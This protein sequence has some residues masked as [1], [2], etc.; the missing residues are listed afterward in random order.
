LHAG[1]KIKEK[2]LKEIGNSS[3]I[4]SY[5]AFSADPPT[6]CFCEEITFWGGGYRVFPGVYPSIVFNLKH[7]LKCLFLSSH[8]F[9]SEELHHEFLSSAL[10]ILN[11]SEEIARRAKI[12]RYSDFFYKTSLYVP[13][14]KELEEL[15]RVVLFSEK[16]LEEVAVKCSITLKNIN[17]LFSMIGE[18]NAH[19]YDF[20]N[21]QLLVQ[22]ILQLEKNYIVTDP[23][24]LL[25]SFWQRVHKKI[26]EKGLFD[27]FSK[28]YYSAI[29]DSVI[30]YFGF[31]KIQKVPWLGENFQNNISL[32]DGVFFFDNDKALIT[33]LI[34]NLFWKPEYI[35]HNI[36]SLD[37]R[38]KLLLEKICKLTSAPNEIMY[39]FLFPYNDCG[40]TGIEVLNQ[41]KELPSDCRTLALSLDSLEIISI[42]EGG[43]SLFLYKY[44]QSQ[45]KNRLKTEIISIHPLSDYGYFRKQGYSYYFSDDNVNM[46]NLTDDIARSTR[47]EALKKIDAHSVYNPHRNSYTEVVRLHDERLPLYMPSNITST[48]G[49]LLEN[50]KLPIWFYNDENLTRYIRYIAIEF[51]DMLGYWIYEMRDYINVLF[52][53]L[54]YQ[55]KHLLIYVKFSKKDSWNEPFIGNDLPRE[56]KHLVITFKHPDIIE[57]EFFP[58]INSLIYGETNKGERFILSQFIKNMRNLYTHFKLS[59]NNL[60]DQ[61]IEEIIDK[62]MPISKKKKLSVYNSLIVP[63]IDPR[64][65]PI[66]RVVDEIDIDFLLDEIGEVIRNK[67][68]KIGD[69]NKEQSE[70]INK[71]IVG[72][73][74]EKLQN[75]IRKINGDNLLY[76]LI[77]QNEALTRDRKLHEIHLPMRLKISDPG[78]VIKEFSKEYHQITESGPA[79][80][81]L[82]ECAISLY[83]KGFRSMSDALYDKLL[84]I[85]VEIIN[86]GFTSD[87]VFYHIGDMRVRILPSGRI[88]RSRKEYE[89][90]IERFKGQILKRQTEV[91]SNRFN[92]Y[93]GKK[94]QGEVGREN[95]PNWDEIEFALK[96]EFGFTLTD[97]IKFDKVITDM[98]GKKGKTI[99][100][101]SKDRLLEILKREISFESACA[102]IEN[103]S[104]CQRKNF[105]SHP[106]YK[107]IQKHEFF[108]WRFNRLFSY[109]RRPL[110]EIQTEERI[111]IIYGLRHWKAAVENFTSLLQNGRLTHHAKTKEFRQLLTKIIQPHGLH[112]NEEVANLFD[113]NQKFKV[114]K[115]KT[116]FGKTKIATKKGEDLGDIDVFVIDTKSHKL[117]IIEC[118]DLLIARTPYEL[119]LEMNKIFDDENSFIKKH[120]KRIEWITENFQIVLQ[121][122]LLDHRKKWKVKPLLIVNE[123]LFSSHFKNKPG[124][125]ILTFDELKIQ[126]LR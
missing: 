101:I 2:K 114:Y 44:A 60:S 111:E 48:I 12:I 73:L 49:V 61:Q 89:K 70:F 46:I 124:L 106:N 118:K 74:W 102:I 16:E 122:C 59:Y 115:N 11:I 57:L 105:F 121:S 50:I 104:L 63:E 83:P 42:L 41:L 32:I 36:Q 68:V 123:P 109:I 30:R 51:V 9:L 22:P 119:N 76:Y 26:I 113:K 107:Q 103:M 15:A 23:S 45:T 108:P 85:A 95:D 88:G 93:W 91:L 19:S 79:C 35:R 5:I 29:W 75:E 24:S 110:L 53:P 100:K 84:A 97:F 21:G 8:S 54:C 56:S 58:E 38:I 17:W 96:K 25:N 6:Q 52:E 72:Y 90:A 62:Y 10:F 37:D 116:K 87:L 81:F 14:A 94:T 39:I 80:R 64:D 31:M 43:K 92:L 120:L 112:F 69:E 13:P 47:L 78:E 66:T 1:P 67:D 126:V 20:E 4:E 86:W 34:G 82:I 40:F 98:T 28:F 99:I 7:L 65:I 71:Y 27:D 33:F 18:V 125:K 117:L 77:H 55:I 3:L